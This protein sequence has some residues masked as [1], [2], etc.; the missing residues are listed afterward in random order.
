M[1]TYEVAM[2]SR[3]LNRWRI[4]GWGLGAPLLLLPFI[5][6]Q[7]STEVDW[8]VSDFVFAGGLIA[9]VGL[10]Y[11]LTLRMS[12]DLVYRAAFAVALATA[13]LIVWANAAVGMIGDGPNAYNLAFLGVIALLVLGSAGV[14]GRPAGMVCLILMCAVLH[15]CVALAGATIDWRGGIMSGIFVFPWLVSAALFRVAV[16]RQSVRPQR[17]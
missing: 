14:R 3:I 6:M 11:E 13:F 7:F 2:G 12:H 4:A 5:A 9:M 1:K 16:T 10:A 17:D 8:T 15:G